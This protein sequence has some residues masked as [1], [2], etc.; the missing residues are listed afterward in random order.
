MSSGENNAVQ[1]NV[2]RE[3]L[4]EE[5]RTLLVR[6]QD[7]DTK[8]KYVINYHGE[9]GSGASWLESSLW[10]EAQKTP[11]YTALELDFSSEKMEPEEALESLIRDLKE[12]GINFWR[13]GL[14]MQKLGRDWKEVPKKLAICCMVFAVGAVFGL[15][16]FSAWLTPY[17][18]NVIKSFLNTII[19]ILGF[20]MIEPGTRWFFLRVKN[21][22]IKKELQKDYPEFG[23]KWNNKR[24]ALWRERLPEM[25]AKDVNAWLEKHPGETLCIFIDSY[26]RKN[27]DRW[28]YGEQGLCRNLNRT[29]FAITG[30]EPLSWAGEDDA[31]KEN[32]R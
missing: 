14:V 3:D 26:E 22:G 31:W 6:A 2:S 1:E 8:N 23:G 28:L 27:D 7:K 20:K 29:G 30:H 17:V 32:R 18:P 13:F 19:G 11:G 24:K 10:Q 16:F 12:K 9:P 21:T 25:F 5:F 15:N 4:I